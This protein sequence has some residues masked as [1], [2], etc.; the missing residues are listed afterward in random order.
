MM[1]RKFKFVQIK[2]ALS[3]NVLPAIQ[4]SSHV[5]ERI[6]GNFFILQERNPQW[7]NKEEQAN[8]EEE[9]AYLEP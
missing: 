8:K 9:K 3:I 4:T 1:I 7:M 2:M 6:A 5:F